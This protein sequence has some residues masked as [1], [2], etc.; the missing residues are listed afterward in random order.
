MWF[1]FQ[2]LAEDFLSPDF[3]HL[4]V[5]RVGSTSENIEQNVLWLDETEKRVNL[6][7]ILDNEGRLLLQFPYY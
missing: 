6:Q 5:G 3:I 7:R 1:L 2:K 4:A